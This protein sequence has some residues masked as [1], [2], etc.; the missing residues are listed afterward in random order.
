MVEIG[1]LFRRMKCPDEFGCF[2]FGNESGKCFYCDSEEG[3]I[4]RAYSLKGCKA[5]EGHFYSVVREEV[6]E[7]NPSSG[8]YYLINTSRLIKLETRDSGKQYQRGY[9]I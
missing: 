4:L 3:E 5:N 2:T 6:P 9:N 7:G 1:D 8:Q